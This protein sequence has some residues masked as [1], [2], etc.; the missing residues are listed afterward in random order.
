MT[1][2]FLNKELA[3][4]AKEKG[5]DE[6]CFAHYREDGNLVM[7][8]CGIAGVR[9]SYIVESPLLAPLYQ[10]I[11]DWFREKYEILIS[12]ISHDVDNH[13]FQI[14]DQNGNILESDDQDDDNFENYYSAL[15]EAIEEAFKLI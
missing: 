5:F 13:I 1:H 2:L 10:Q 15:N 8:S 3:Q 9:Y 11:I 6:P 7:L 4:T 12:I 14:I